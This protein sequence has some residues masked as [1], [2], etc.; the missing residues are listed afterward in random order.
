MVLLEFVFLEFLLVVID[1]FDKGL[2]VILKDWI[3][4]FD[5]FDVFVFDVYFLF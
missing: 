5:L 4:V 3:L 1:F 2:D